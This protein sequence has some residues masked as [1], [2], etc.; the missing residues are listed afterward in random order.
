MGEVDIN[1]VWKQPAIV[2]R[3]GMMHCTSTTIASTAPVAI[4]LPKGDG[5]FKKVI[6]D[7]MRR[8]IY[9]A[10]IHAIYRTWFESPIPPSGSVLNMP[11]S[12]LL[13]DFW[14]YPTD[15]VPF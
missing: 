4:M 11:I 7:E 12:Y 10:E 9:S 14:K 13:R 15:Q 8:L 1:L 2:P 5:A 6:D 3:A